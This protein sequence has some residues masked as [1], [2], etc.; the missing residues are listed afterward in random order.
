[1]AV[2]SRKIASATSATHPFETETRRS[3]S[4]SNMRTST[5]GLLIFAHWAMSST[6]SRPGIELGKV[7]RE[8]R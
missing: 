8:E 6:T 7:V 5:Y 2:K 4:R 3:E 1:M